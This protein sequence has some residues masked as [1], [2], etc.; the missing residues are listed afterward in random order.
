MRTVSERTTENHI[1]PTTGVT[2]KA[3][4]QR[5]RRVR[6]VMTSVRAGGCNIKQGKES[7]SKRSGGDP[8][9]LED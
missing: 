9:Q 6:N 2:W 1:R 7:V 8:R 5:L 4:K 3:R